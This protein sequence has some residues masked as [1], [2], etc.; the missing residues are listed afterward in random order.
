MRTVCVNAKRKK[1]TTQI[2]CLLIGALLPY[3][4]AGVTGR[5]RK[6]QFGNIGLSEPLAQARQLSGAGARAWGAQM[7]AWEALLVFAAANGAALAAGVEPTG[8]WALAAAL[9]AAVRILHGVF[10]VAGQAGLRV[11]AFAAGLAMSLW[12]FWLALVAA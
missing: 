6:R 8:D 5:Y 2:V 4:W 12:I 1:V 7:N 11:L 3:F 9:W 10:Y